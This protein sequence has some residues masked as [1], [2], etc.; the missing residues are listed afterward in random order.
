MSGNK[1]I[2]VFPQGFFYKIKAQCAS[3]GQNIHICGSCPLQLG[4][5]H[6]IVE[7]F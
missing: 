4:L 7:Y 6:S 5:Y 2:P 3:T 1:K